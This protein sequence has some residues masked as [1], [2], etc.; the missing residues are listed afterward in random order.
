[1]TADGA[2]P[3]FDAL[4]EITATRLA[5]Q[6]GPELAVGYVEDRLARLALADV[7]TTP[8]PAG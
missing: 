7:V 3:V 8:D 6:L 2:Q 4:A 5:S 1:M